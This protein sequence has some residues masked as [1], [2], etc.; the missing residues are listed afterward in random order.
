M[1]EL[2]ILVIPVFNTGW[3]PVEYTLLLRAREELAEFSFVFICS[4]N[5][6]TG[7]ISEEFPEAKIYRFAPEFFNDRMGYTRLLLRPDLYEICGWAEYILLFE[8]NVFIVKNQLRYWCKQGHDYIS[9]VAG[10]LSLRHVDTFMSLTR[11][12]NRSIY[13]FLNE[14]T[15]YENDRSYWQ[16]KAGGIWPTLR[17]PTKIVSGYFSLPIGPVVVSLKTVDQPFALTDIDVKSDEH[18]GWIDAASIKEY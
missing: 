4:E 9:D 16:K 18:R 10:Y 3:S 7:A 6:D 11:R 2:A 8:P 14:A 13:R 12:G 15:T 17:S 1:R 5:A